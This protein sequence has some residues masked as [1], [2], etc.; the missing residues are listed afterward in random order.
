[1]FDVA[2]LSGRALDGVYWSATMKEAGA[3]VRATYSTVSLSA[4]SEVGGGIGQ[5]WVA[6]FPAIDWEYLFTDR[7]GPVY[8]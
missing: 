6:D 3:L 7:V 1:M 4:M 5:R 2:L 8:Q